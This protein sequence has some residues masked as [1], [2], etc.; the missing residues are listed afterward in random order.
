MNNN[1]STDKD[2]INETDNNLVTVY[3]F[4]NSK[5]EYQINSRIINFS[6][7]FI[8]TTKRFSSQLF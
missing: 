1:N 7:A 6:I 2:T 4:G 5:Y 8:F 3:L